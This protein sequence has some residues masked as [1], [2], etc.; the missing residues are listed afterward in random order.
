MGI[1]SLASYASCRRGYE[2]YKEKKVA[3]SIRVSD[4]EYIGKVNGSGKNIYN[5]K[6]DIEHPRKS[7]CDCPH[8]NGKRIVCKHQVALYFTAFPKEAEDYCQEVVLAEE[9]AERIREE[10]EVEVIKVVGKMEKDELQQVLLEILFD[11]PEW[12]YDGFVRRYTD[13][14]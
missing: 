1:L 10:I 2:Y 5:V 3:E 6:I 9:E 4:S 11:G 13:Y 12:Q 8:A 14:W 7:S